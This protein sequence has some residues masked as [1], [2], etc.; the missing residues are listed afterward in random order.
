MRT[1]HAPSP[2]QC[3]TIHTTHSS[4]EESM[5]SPHRMCRR[6]SHTLSLNRN[7]EDHLLSE[8]RLNL[9]TRAIPPPAQAAPGGGAPAG[10]GEGRARAALR[11]LAPRDRAPGLHTFCSEVVWGPKNFPLVPQ[12]RRHVRSSRHVLIERKAKSNAG[13][14]HLLLIIKWPGATPAILLLQLLLN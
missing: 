9:V 12:N 1:L 6:R 3:A 10:R 5:W 11:D 7:G 2:S 8:K 4:G 13:G 14:L